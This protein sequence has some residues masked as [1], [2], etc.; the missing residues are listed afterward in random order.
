VAVEV[1]LQLLVPG[2]QWFIKAT[3]G[4]YNNIRF[5]ENAGKIFEA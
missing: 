3:K 4:I 5:K 1:E 2:F